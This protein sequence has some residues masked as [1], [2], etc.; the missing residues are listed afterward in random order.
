MSVLVAME[1][2]DGDGICVCSAGV[3]VVLKQVY[4]DG[5]CLW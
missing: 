5:V 4:F 1:D 3:F 2:V